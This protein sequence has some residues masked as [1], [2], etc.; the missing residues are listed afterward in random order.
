L[1]GLRWS[2]YADELDSP[3]L[4]RQ[5]EVQNQRREQM[6]QEL[7]SSVRVQVNERIGIEN[8]GVLIE[9]GPPY[10]VP[11]APAF[12]ALHG[13]HP[14]IHFPASVPSG[15]PS[16][17]PSLS[18]PVPTKPTTPAPNPMQWNVPAPRDVNGPVP[19]QG[20]SSLKSSVIR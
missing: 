5:K 18:S 20:E 13:A 7:L 10:G 14:E 2:P 16:I 19:K 6:R 9:E 15:P 12:P 3:G 1:M 17:Q 4:V 11:H 8:R